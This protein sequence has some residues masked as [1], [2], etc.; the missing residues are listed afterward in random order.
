[1]NLQT[2]LPQKIQ[3]SLNLNNKRYNSLLLTVNKTK[4]F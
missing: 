4:N 1:M 3:G 2:K